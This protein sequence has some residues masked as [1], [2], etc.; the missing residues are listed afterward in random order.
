[1]TLLFCYGSNHPAQLAARLGHA[2]RN[3]GAFLLDTGRVFRGW[4]ETWQGGVAS[5]RRMRGVT[6]FGYVAQITAADL[7]QMDAF[8]GVRTGHYRRERVSVQTADGDRDAVA[9]VSQSPEKRRPSARYLEAVC[10]T[11]G[12]FWEGERG[13]VRPSDIVI[14]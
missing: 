13:P 8:E 11:I 12:S 4:S 2:T 7:R 3:E 9:Y 6:T 10:L 14:R 5:L 1:M